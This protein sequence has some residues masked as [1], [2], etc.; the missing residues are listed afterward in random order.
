[1]PRRQL[2]N[3]S[4]GTLLQVV[5]NFRNFCDESTDLGRDSMARPLRVRSSIKGATMFGVDVRHYRL[6]RVGLG[7][8]SR[9]GGSVS[10]RK[11]CNRIGI[12]VRQSS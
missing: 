3:Q 10:F 7:F 9:N 4:T 1:M 11:G 8:S 5:S 12:F 2:I 6:C